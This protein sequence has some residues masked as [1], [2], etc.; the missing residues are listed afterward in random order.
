MKTVSF[1][2]DYI[3]R[4]GKPWFPVMGELHYSRCPEKYW[5]ES[6]YKMKA[7]GVSVVSSYVI[8]IHHE[9]VRGEYDFSGS[10]NLRGFLECVKE[11]GLYMF[12][13]IG[14]WSHAE[15]RNGGFPDWLVQSGI[16]LRTND[17][18]YTEEVGRFW[19]EIYRHTSGHLFKD[20]GSVIG[21][22]LENELGHC[23]GVGGSE[24]ERHM[25][26][27]YDIAVGIGFDVPLYTATGWGGAVTGGLLPVM[28]GYCEAPWEQTDEELPPSG[29]YVF[30]YERNDHSI[31]SD[32]GVG[33]QLTFDP[34]RFPYLTAE[35]GGGLQVTGHRRPIAMAEDIGAMTLVKLGSGCNLLG[36]YMYHGGTNPR[37]RLSTLQESRS[38]GSLNDLPEL[39]YDFRAPI[40]EYGQIT[41]TYK[42]LRLTALFAADFGE[43]LCGMRAFIPPEN[44]LS[45]SNL[46]ALR[47]SLRH[48]GESGYIFVNNY[49]RRYRMAEHNA[50]ILTVEIGGERI[51]LPPVDIKNGDYF[52]L[53]LN[54]KI[55]GAVLR[56]AFATP[57]CI[58]NGRTYVF[59][60]D[61]DPLY[62]LSGSLDD[63][64]IITLSRADA[65]N[66]CKIRL[67]R[68]YL[69]ISEDAVVTDS[70]GVVLFAQ[71]SSPIKIY[72]E[73]P[74]EPKGYRKTGVE[75][76]FSVYK[77]RVLVPS[78]KSSFK[79]LYSTSDSTVYELSIE[80][81][82]GVDDCFVRLDF[83]GDSARLYKDGK[84]I[85]DAFY[86]GAGWY[87]GLKRFDFPSRLVAEIYPLSDTDGIFLERS[88]RYENGRASS[89]DGVTAWCERQIRIYPLP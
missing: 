26:L 76:G 48:N 88:P 62:S 2:P 18:R 86:T 15:V 9:E 14:P 68:D 29:N 63:A 37:G 5:R 33:E 3:T 81:P 24:G 4:G 89:L 13:R 12:L 17:P 53:P 16:P 1:T 58:L 35:L 40:G 44:P 73:P 82:Q 46:T 71:H 54:M 31:G 67:D 45:P 84:L 7:G 50:E 28:G 6:L 65:L 80:Y 34:A 36:Y 72:P 11:C 83:S 66:A 85:A 38:S 42:E 60:S 61:T 23:G 75:N 78:A 30:T 49:C 43:E 51:T 59:Y 20:G 70:S 8:W 79:L 22:Q 39:S 69:V 57:L 77:P 52:F 19:S 47:Y 32:H 55:G 74:A 25:R 41:P 10:R 21:I 56:F 27:L 87:V 64:E